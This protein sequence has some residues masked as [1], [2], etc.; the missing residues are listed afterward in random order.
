MAQTASFQN[1]RFAR[2]YV[3][4]AE[5]ADRR[6]AY[7]HRRRLLAGLAG[8]VVEVGAGNGLNFAHYPAAVTEVVA[9]EPDDTLRAHAAAAA[10]SAPVPVTVVTGHSEDLPGGAGGFDAAVTSLVLCTVPSPARALAEIA[11]VL[12]PGGV[13]RFYEHVRSP[14]PVVGLFEDLIAPAWR[15][16]AGGCRLNLDALAAIRRAGFTVEDADR[17]TFSPQPGM[18]RL[19]HVTGRARLPRE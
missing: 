15:R 13:L 12:R 16:A 3:T 14:N 18:P 11:R 19:T 10:A 6:G 2:A 5:L 17:F 4:A 9:V 8:R 1:P 7:E